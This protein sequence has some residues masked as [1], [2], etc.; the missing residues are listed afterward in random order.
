MMPSSFRLRS[1]SAA[2]L[3]AALLTASAAAQETTRVSVDSSGAESNG[4]SDTA[5]VSA[6]AR[7]VAFESY[8]SDLV[9]GDT[10]G[11][12]DIFVH[13]GST[14]ITER[15]SVDSSGVEGNDASYWPS[16][17]PDGRFVAF[18]S[19][20]SDLV[21]SDLN[22]QT[23]VF[24]HDRSTGITERVSVDSTGAEGNGGSGSFDYF[25]APAISADAQSVAFVS[26]ASN[27]VGGDTNGVAD[28]FVHDRVTGITERV[29][30]DSSGVE[31]TDGSFAQAISLDGNVVAFWS[32][33]SNLVVG[34]TNGQPDVFVHDRSTGVT[35]RVSVDSTGVE[36]KDGSFFNAG[37]SI[38]ADGQL[39]VFCSYASNLVSGDTNGTADV[40]V[41]DRSTGVTE[42]VSVT[43]AG[44]GGNGSSGIYGPSISA[45]GQI[46]AFTSLAS[47]LVGGDGNGSYDG[48]VHDRATGINER[49]SVDS[50][51]AEAN[52]ASYFSSISS[53]GRF[54]G[55]GSFASNLVTGDTNGFDDVFVHDRCMID[56][57]WSNYGVGFAGTIGVPGLTSRSEPTLGSNITLDLANSYGRFTVGLLFVG[58]QQTDLH[59]T[60]GGD[61]LV[62]P[63]FTLVVALPASGV[64][65]TSDIPDDD[66]L[67]G[68]TSDLQAIE[69]DPGAAKGVSFTPGLE[70]VMGR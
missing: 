14:G 22:G 30:V 58:F 68:F 70:L 50:S 38:S 43:S 37:P 48:F 18:F 24:V 56:A 29:S 67:C 52:E 32:F 65:L 41:H 45:D 47:D 3:G 66:R 2:G 36:G 40:F 11:N 49:F 17:A 27:L 39:V 16:I 12:Y 19:D 51:G 46:V 44:A 63:V 21:F 34:D 23:D 33:A 62:V 9:A 13:D 8:A 26:D 42:G 64:S 28:I 61:L 7:I 31:G 57:T 59:S 1:L 6:D 35:E 10:N 53:S 60:W 54:V 5:A 25:G 20:A 15:V 55:F 4:F 69:V